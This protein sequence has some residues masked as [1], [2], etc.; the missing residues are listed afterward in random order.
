MHCPLLLNYGSCTD[1]TQL[2]NLGIHSIN[3]P[4]LSI[5]I[6]VLCILG[7]S[8]WIHCVPH[9]LICERDFESEFK[10]IE[11]SRQHFPAKLHV[12]RVLLFFKNQNKVQSSIFFSVVKMLEKFRI[13]RIRCCRL[14]FHPWPDRTGVIKAADWQIEISSC[15]YQMLLQFFRGFFKN[16]LGGRLE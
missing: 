10:Q 14:G 5:H 11:F 7:Y 9:G 6:G 2:E 1:D 16:P 13:F 12:A 3:G 15:C 4:V 8:S